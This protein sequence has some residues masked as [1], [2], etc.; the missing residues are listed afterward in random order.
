MCPGSA[1]PAEPGAV[2]IWRGPV[3]VRSWTRRSSW[4]RTPA[5]SCPPDWASV[6]GRS[7][8]RCCTGCWRSTAG[9]WWAS[10]GWAGKWGCCCR[11]TPARPPVWC[12]PGAGTGGTGR[13]AE[14]TAFWTASTDLSPDWTEVGGPRLWRWGATGFWASS[15]CPWRRPLRGRRIWVLFSIVASVFCVDGICSPDVPSC[16]TLWNNGNN[17]EAIIHGLDRSGINQAGI[18]SFIPEGGG[19]NKQSRG[20][21]S[22]C[23]VRTKGGGAWKGP[24]WRTGDWRQS[25][26][27]D[28]L[29][30]NRDHRRCSMCP[31]NGGIIFCRQLNMLA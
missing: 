7:A 31:Y 14:G 13:V 3:S 2:F 19:G 5:A 1:F 10:S 20:K 26:P 4:W 21:Y 11:A 23:S 9:R 25:S 24:L 16:A 17:Y 18:L 28:N 15:G 12:R 27:R 8:G 22:N 6:G 29:P 30:L